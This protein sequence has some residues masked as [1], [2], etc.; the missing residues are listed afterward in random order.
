MPDIPMMTEPRGDADRA[1]MEAM[2]G[3]MQDMQ[4]MEMTGDPGTDFA[5]MMIPHH[6]SAVDMAEAYLE[7]GNDPEL[8]RLAEDIVRT[9]P[10]EIDEFEAWLEENGRN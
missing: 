6:Q 3:M 4:A 9:Q 7:H 10:K 1:Y 2:H 5:R 8:R